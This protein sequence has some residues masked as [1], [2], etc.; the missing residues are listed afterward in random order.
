[1]LN[2][3]AGALKNVYFAGQMV[4]S[5]GLD[6]AVGVAGARLF[7]ASFRQEAAAGGDPVERLL[8][9]QLALAHL[10]VARLHALAAQSERLEFK[11]LYTNAAV[12]LLGA[13]AQLVGALTA[14]RASARPRQDRPRAGGRGGTRGQ[15]NKGGSAPKTGQRSEK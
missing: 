11:Q 2:R 7:L 14:Y 4:S 10:Q 1:V 13:T 5:L 3:Q 15:R 12:R 8:L 9:D 6:D